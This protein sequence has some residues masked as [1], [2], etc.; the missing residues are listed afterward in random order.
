MQKIVFV[1][2]MN[3]SVTSKIELEL[4]C[5]QFGGFGSKCW[6]TF[7][8]LFSGKLE[9]SGLQSGLLIIGNPL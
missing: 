4:S 1:I 7:L 2:R 3:T 8:Q 9:L 6:L 5:N